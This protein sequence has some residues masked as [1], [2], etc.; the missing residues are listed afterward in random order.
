[1]LLAPIALSSEKISTKQVRLQQFQPLQKVPFHLLYKTLM[2]D[3]PIYCVAEN[4]HAEEL[5]K[6]NFFADM[7]ECNTTG[8]E[9]VRFV[10]KD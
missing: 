3:N 10:I 4:G 7:Y 1:M 5:S 9:I 6:D 2:P 8:G